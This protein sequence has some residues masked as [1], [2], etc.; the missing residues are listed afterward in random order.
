MSHGDRCSWIKETATVIS[1][2]RQESRWITYSSLNVGLL[3]NTWWYV[4]DKW[5]VRIC[6]A[7]L[8][9]LVFISGA[10]LVQNCALYMKKTS[11][12][13]LFQFLITSKINR[14]SGSNIQ[15][16]KNVIYSW[17]LMGWSTV[18]AI[19]VRERY[20]RTDK[21]GKNLY[22]KKGLENRNVAYNKRY[23]SHIISLLCICHL[24]S[25]QCLAC[26]QVAQKV[27][28]DIIIL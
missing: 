18:N 24:W 3:R 6:K 9:F 12:A 8:P 28:A 13:Q 21:K 20:Q 14:P 11:Q 4:E 22:I 2:G 19:W 26:L 23:H 5:K 1:G 10:E 25:H 27:T 17:G 15:L 7:F 16:S